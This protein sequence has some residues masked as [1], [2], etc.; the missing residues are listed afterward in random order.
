M[1]AAADEKRRA[2]QNYRVYGLPNLYVAG[3]SVFPTSGHA[4]PTLM[5]LAF[6][7]RLADH[8]NSDLARV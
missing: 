2:D 4:N 6:A 7:I 8:L 5:I 1:S 3:G